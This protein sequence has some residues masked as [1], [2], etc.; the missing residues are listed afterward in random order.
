MNSDTNILK[1]CGDRADKWAE[2]F[3]EI[4]NK[5]VREEH[6]LE[7][8]ELDVGWITGWFAN[9][10]EYSSDV[11]RWGNEHGKIYDWMNERNLTW[12]L[13]KEDRILFDLTW[14]HNDTE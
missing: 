3:C 6:N 11:R 9:A 13:S 7:S 12:P 5:A 14:N 1:Y 10:I 2:K 8:F 4:V